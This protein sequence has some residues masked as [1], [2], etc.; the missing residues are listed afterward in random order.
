MKPLASQAGGFLLS[1]HITW[2]ETRMLAGLLLWGF[3][4][5]I[6]SVEFIGDENYWIAT[7]VR[8][9]MLLAGDFESP[10]W[11][12]DPTIVYEVRP[13]PSYLAGMGQRLGG[14]QPA[15]LPG[16]YWNW[17]LSEAENAA[18]GAMPSPHVIWWSRISMTVIAALGLLGI[19]LFLGRIHSRIAAYV[20][21]LISFNAYFLDT[22]RRSMSEASILFFTILALLASVQLLIVL[23]GASWKRVV[24]W[25]ALAGVFSGLAGE[26][27]LTG[28]ACAAVPVLGALIIISRGEDKAGMP[29]MRLFLVVLFVITT[30]TL[31]TFIA[32]YPLF[33]RE[34][35]DRVWE[36]FDARRQILNYQLN[37]YSHQLIPAGAR[38]GILFQRIFEYPIRIQSSPGMSAILHWINF[39]PAAIGLFYTVRQGSGA[40]SLSHACLALWLGA[41]FSAG[42][43]LLTPFDWERYYMFPIFFA[44]VFFSIGSVQAIVQLVTWLSRADRA[45]V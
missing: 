20:F 35:V 25:S 38:I 30:A 15:D 1:R 3:T 42:P 6:L 41:A 21:T 24:F 26:S 34:T 12:E 45:P 28:L 10:L 32:T 7:S 37:T 43:M 17:N 23:R 33:Y 31:L 39:I 29:K 9:D 36:T 27:K 11:T 19:A 44:C 18:R 4:R 16:A 40:S 13:V 2:L 22:L 5:N 14:I 8:L